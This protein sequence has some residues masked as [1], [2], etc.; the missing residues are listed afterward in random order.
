MLEVEYLIKRMIYQMLKFF[1]IISS[2][3]DPKTSILL[4]RY[5]K[6]RFINI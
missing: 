1:K 6:Y 2:R 3:D 4:Q 5:K